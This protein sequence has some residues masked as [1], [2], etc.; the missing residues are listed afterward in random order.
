MLI[1]LSHGCLELDTK[2]NPANSSDCLGSVVIV[3]SILLFSM[4]HIIITHMHTCAAGGKVIGHGVHGLLSIVLFAACFVYFRH[5][6]TLQRPSFQDISR[7]LSL[8]DTKLLKWTEEDKAVHPAMPRCLM[9][10]LVWLIA[11]P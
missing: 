2:L 7:Q 5:P 10:V 11:Q 3:S 8:P 4:E 6:E 1:L 9:F